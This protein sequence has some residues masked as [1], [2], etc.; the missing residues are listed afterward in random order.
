MSAQAANQEP[1]RPDKVWQA[2]ATPPPV[3]A[4]SEQGL[5]SVKPPAPRRI[6]DSRA[7]RLAAAEDLKTD[8]QEHDES[9]RPEGWA[10]NRFEQCFLG[11]R[12]VHLL[13]RQSGVI[14]A[15]IEFEY[16]LL[17]FA[18]DG[19]RKVNYVFDFDDFDTSGGEPLQITTLTVDFA[20]CGGVVACSPDPP[21]AS[22]LVPDWQFGNRHFEFSISSPNEA[23]D[24]TFLIA[25]SLI[26]MNMSIVTVAPDVLP[27]R[28]AVMTSSRVRFDSAKSAL[29]A[30]KFY[31]AVF[32]DHV[33]TLEFDKRPGSA[34]LEEARH[35]DDA[36]HSPWRTFPSFAGKS[37]PGEGARPLHR[38]MNA[39]LKDKNNEVSVGI[40]KD[41]WG[42][43]Y[44]AGGRECDEFPFKTTYEG[45]ATS[46]GATQDNP[47]GGN[48][49]AWH[50]SARPISGAHNSAGGT[51]LLVFLGQ[52]R[53]LDENV[54]TALEG[55]PS[56]PYLVKVLS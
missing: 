10:R 36:L 41:V 27:W 3:T 6:T 35:I 38:L 20:G 29:G 19:S 55:T 23:G 2:T 22:K 13:S 56:D 18:V 39:T 45:S 12:K 49:S 8:C 16:S 24:G 25:R 9:R 17:A 33:P 21:L 52:N 26:Q 53:V 30:G 40:C 47:N 31:G 28:E 11:K 51:H 5:R 32:S 1:I 46:T 44:A 15:T 48:G 54:G 37:V 14:V 34:Y 42:A 4:P 50:G 7:E 43:G